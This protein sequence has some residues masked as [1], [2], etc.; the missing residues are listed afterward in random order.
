MVFDTFIPSKMFDFMSCGKPIIL[1]VNGEARRIFAEA[2]AGIYVKPENFYDL[3]DTIITLYENPELCRRYGE[4]G[5]N[6][7]IRHF[8]RK[9]QAQKL[10][11]LFEGLLEPT[12]LDSH[13]RQPLPLGA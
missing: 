12:E 4:N 3:S 6:Y 9:E 1:S 2:D 7:V 5:R 13:M 11:K 10:E 8:S